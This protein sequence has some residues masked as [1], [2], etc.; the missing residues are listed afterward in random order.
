MQVLLLV[1]QKN[2][3]QPNLYFQGKSN[4][5]LKLYKSQMDNIPLKDTIIKSITDDKNLVGEGRT[6]K[7]YSLVGL[8]DYVIRIYKN[9]FKKEDLQQ[10]F[11]DP[12]TYLDRLNDVVLSIPGKIDIAKK[13]NGTGVGIKDFAARIEAHKFPPMK[14]VYATRTE[15]LNSLKLYEQLQNF[16]LQS[17][18]KAYRQLKKFCQKPGFQFDVISPGNILVDINKKTINLIDPLEPEI[19]NAVHGGLLDFSNDHGC[20]SL[21]PVLCDFLMHKEHMANLNSEE[22]IRWEKAINNIISKCIAAGEKI[23]YKRNIEN[24]KTLYGRIG[25][26]WKT[27]EIYN[28]YVNFVNKYSD[29]I[30]KDN[31]IEKALNHKNSEHI[32]IE[33]INRLNAQNFKEIKPVF[34]KIIEAP[35]QVKVE[36]PEILN[37][38]IDKLQQYGKNAESIMPSLE[39]LFEKEIFYPTKKRLYNLFIT[40]Q[41][42]N[43]QFLKEIR[44]SANNIFEKTLYEHE[45]KRLESY[46]KNASPKNKLLIKEICQEACTGEKEPLDVVKKL[47]ISRTC[48]KSGKEQLTS[49]KNMDIAYN[50]INLIKNNIPKTSDLIDIHKIV[51]ANTPGQEHI[52]G[53]LRTPETD[54]ILMQIFN[55]TKSLKN[56]INPYSDSKDVI[57]DL[58][59]LDKYIK[60]NYNKLDPFQLAANV[61]SEVIRI[62]PFLNGNGRTTRLFT[63]QI[64]LGKGYYLTE[65]P[66]EFLYRKLYTDEELATFLKQKST[67]N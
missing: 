1:S 39:K 24:L 19:N 9:A 66:E 61:F 22:T 6:K 60:L 56:T 67:K 28:R 37:A 47:W 53:L 46:I 58:E 52:A 10:K 2:N 21:Y 36:I 62:H 35:H 7:V 43:N 3:I 40:I 31:I 48:S 26:F 27:N 51:L 30:N 65:W 16:P 8:K 32:R 49:L 50:Y 57:K 11:L 63:E 33:A 42:E 54:H 41:P 55:I 64:L 13:K 38:A 34:E 15:T 4:S 17:Y 29:T 20:D 44:K 45:F 25:K 12:Q 5:F 23:G 59:K 14:N 18:E